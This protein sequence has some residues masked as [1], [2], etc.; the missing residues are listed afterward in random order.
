MAFNPP[1]D[2]DG[3]WV[4]EFFAPWLDDKHPCPAAPGELRWFAAIDGRDV[5]MPSGATFVHKGEEITPQSRT[6]IPSKIADNP[7]LLKTGYMATLQSLPEPLRSQML[8]GD[9][10]AGMEDDQWQIIP[11]AW[12]ETAMAR[13][14]RPAKLAQMDSMGV[15]VARGGKDETIIMRR[16]DM[17]F[18]EPMP[19]P[20]KA[21]PDG[22]TIAGLVIAA[23]RDRAPIHIDVIGVGS[24]PYDFLKNL[25]QQVIGVNV[26][27]SATDTDRSGRLRFANLRAQL[28]W[29]MREALDPVSNTGIALP[30]SRLLL[31]DL[32][33]PKWSIRGSEISVESREDIVKRLGRSPDYGSACVLALIDTPRVDSLQ[34]GMVKAGKVQAYDPYANMR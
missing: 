2:V 20:G 25:R 12:V 22:P 26:S 1:T 23:I 13:W 29:K 8:Y 19:H 32:T 34:A 24:S 6:F 27:E 30:R 15:D 16:H 9:F 28:W 11:T 14:Q 33:T 21:T 3:R 5:E 18:D 10:R 31:R 4:I 17:W 7:Y